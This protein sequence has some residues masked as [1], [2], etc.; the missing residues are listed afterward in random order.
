[1]ELTPTARVTLQTTKGDIPVDL[2]AKET[3]LA[4]RAF[5]TNCLH[6]TYDGATFNVISAKTVQLGPVENGQFPREFHSRLRF[7]ARG[8]VGVLQ[9][10]NGASAGGFFITT[11][12]A[13]EWNN[14]YVMIGRVVGDAIYNVVK[15]HDG[16][17]EANGAP[18]FPVAVTGVKVETRYF[19]DIEEKVEAKVEPR[20]KKH[21]AATLLYDDEDD[22]DTSF[23]MKSAH[24]VW[25]KKEKTE[26][27]EK[28]EQ[29]EKIV[30][31][32]K[33]E[34]TE[35]MENM[36]KTGKT[37]NTE[38]TEKTEKTQEEQNE[39]EDEKEK[40]AEEKKAGEEEG[41]QEIEAK[42]TEQQKITLVTRRDPAIDPYDPTVDIE[43]D[44]ISFEQLQAHRFVCR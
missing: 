26:K 42:E 22:I 25:G 2:Y 37:E 33:T 16:E 24:Q 7:S 21:K 19:D 12:P 35:N 14:Q 23:V 20:R 13:P 31:T 38:N 39:Q 18:L 41:E 32:E 15:I 8:C 30:K 36:E 5:I 27:T 1:M 43:R 28:T 44:E 11:Q 10:A 40:E 4:C 29:T 6:S 3:P 34:K 17:K 9:S